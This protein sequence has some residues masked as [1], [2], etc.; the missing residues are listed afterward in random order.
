MRFSYLS[1]ATESIP[2][3]GF[4]RRCVQFSV[5]EPVVSLV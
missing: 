1:R 4:I 5:F 2:N 3:G